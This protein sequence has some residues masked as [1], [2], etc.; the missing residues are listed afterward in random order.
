MYTPQATDRLKRKRNWYE[1][2]GDVSTLTIKR[3]DG[4]TVTCIVDTADLPIIKQLLWYVDYQYGKPYI[5]T[6]Q[7]E[8]I[9]TLGRYL[10]QPQDAKLLVGY[11]N[12]NSLDIRRANLFVGDLADLVA[13]R[14]N[15]VA[16]KSGIPNV[17]YVGKQDKWSARQ[18][19]MDE[20]GK[21]RRVHIGL[22]KTVAE[23]TEAIM[24]FR[25][26]NPNAVGFAPQRA[27]QID[28]CESNNEKDK[29]GQS[30]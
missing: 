15:S 28:E 24:R 30:S 29:S 16:T 8:M 19:L 23:A 22:Y 17:N 6:A 20:Y 4:S 3:K 12:H 21:R 2:T 7:T 1:T 11:R 13:N 10:V 25:A 14:I 27:N 18:Y 5:M 26:S 9:T